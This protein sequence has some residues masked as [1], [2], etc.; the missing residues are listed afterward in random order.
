MEFTIYSGG[1]T[2][3]PSAP[4][5]GVKWEPRRFKHLLL[6]TIAETYAKADPFPA[7]VSEWLEGSG[8]VFITFGHFHDGTLI[9]ELEAAANLSSAAIQYMEEQGGEWE[10]SYVWIIN[11]DEPS[12]KPWMRHQQC[13]ITLRK[14]P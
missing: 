3:A 8:L 4:E 12:P 10:S 13:F 1:V 9:F 14:L 6:E 2:A 7:R 11:T 5:G